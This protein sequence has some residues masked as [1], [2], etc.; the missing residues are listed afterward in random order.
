MKN[1]TAHDADVTDGKGGTDP[2]RR[3]SFR[4]F[5]RV[6]R[7][8]RGQEFL[9]RDLVI[10]VRSTR[11]REALGKGDRMRNCAGDKA[12]ALHCAGW[13]ARKR[14]DERTFHHGSKTAR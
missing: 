1:S 8:I 6:I 3:E 5:I 4:F 7:V 12:K 11:C 13:F 9:K 10:K 14:K 2:K